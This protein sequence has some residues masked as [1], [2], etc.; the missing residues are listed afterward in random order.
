MLESNNETM[1]V[2]LTPKILVKFKLSANEVILP[3]KRAVQFKS[4]NTEDMLPYFSPR[5]TSQSKSSKN[6]DN[7]VKLP[8]EISVKL[9]SNI[10][11]FS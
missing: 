8:F 5:T 10:V 6:D 1:S 9:T 3:S 11:S 4:F 2:T 7:P